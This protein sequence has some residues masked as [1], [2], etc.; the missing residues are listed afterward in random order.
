LP[1]DGIVAIYFLT[2]KVLVLIPV[3]LIAAFAMYL[4]YRML[5]EERK[6]NPLWR[7]LCIIPVASVGAFLIWFSFRA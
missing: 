3:V 4:Q 6:Q 2:M 1:V 5:S 7:A